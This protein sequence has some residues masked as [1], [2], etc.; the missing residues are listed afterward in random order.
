MEALYNKM[1]TKYKAKGVVYG[2]LW[3][4]GEGSYPAVELHGNDKDK[5]LE[6]AEGELQ[7]L[8]SGMGFER[9]L[10]A[11]YGVEKIE[12]IKKQSN[13]K[14]YSRSDYQEAI[15]GDLTEEQ[16]EH[17]HNARAEFLNGM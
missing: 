16:V 15:I 3:G 4:G 12:I 10:G 5:M 6:K 17:C 9:I 13:G 7:G 2:K 11:V 8:D 14:D 1:I